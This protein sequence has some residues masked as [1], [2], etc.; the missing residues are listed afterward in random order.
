MSALLYF[1]QPWGELAH[2]SSWNTSYLYILNMRVPSLNVITLADK[3]ITH[4]M[5]STSGRFVVFYRKLNSSCYNNIV[6]YHDLA[7][8]YLKN[9]TLRC[10]LS[11]AIQKY[12]Y[13]N[14]KLNWR[15]KIYI[16]FANVSV[17]KSRYL[18]LL[19]QQ[20]HV[21]YPNRHLY[22]TASRAFAVMS[23]LAGGC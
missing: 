13:L 3:Y 20:T 9:N 17:W 16:E 2:L 8:V 10:E 7:R 4:T 12:I 14:T 15:I 6:L 21:F 22:V 1:E 19:K 23:N 11:L 5:L 18:H